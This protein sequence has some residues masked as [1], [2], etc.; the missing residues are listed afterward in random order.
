MG[1]WF[2]QVL[3]H[4]LSSLLLSYFTGHFITIPGNEKGRIG[5]M[6]FPRELF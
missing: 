5:S 6:P 2:V 1:N 3:S 4:P